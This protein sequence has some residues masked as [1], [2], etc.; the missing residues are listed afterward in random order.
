MTPRRF[1][2]YHAESL[3]NAPELLCLLKLPNH[4]ESFPV[5]IA[6]ISNLREVNTW[7][8]EDVD[9]FLSDDEDV[10]A[11]HEH[12]EVPAQRATLLKSLFRSPRELE[13]AFLIL[14][15]VSENQDLQ[16]DSISI[17]DQI[18]YDL[19]DTG[20]IQ[21]HER[22]ETSKEI[23][24]TVLRLTNYQFLKGEEIPSGNHTVTK[25]SITSK[26]LKA[27]EEHQARVRNS[28]RY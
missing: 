20:Q 12:G 10:I 4:P 24:Y 17:A 22:A 19:L 26:G 15:K 25:Y 13:R 18:Y 8:D 6:K 7:T 27:L 28:R 14:L 16:V 1:H 11:F 21:E 23:K 5:Q 9:I 3:I 2:A